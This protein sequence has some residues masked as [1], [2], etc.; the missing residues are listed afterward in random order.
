LSALVKFH[1]TG[2]RPLARPGGEY[3]AGGEEEARSDRIDPTFAV[4]HMV[5]RLQ[6]GI[7]LL[8]QKPRQLRAL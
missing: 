4:E 7:E 1:P 8:P 3:I 6:F 5:V 2:R